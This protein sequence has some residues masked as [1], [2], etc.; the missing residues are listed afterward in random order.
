M[1]GVGGVAYGSAPLVLPFTCTFMF[2]EFLTFTL[3][4]GCA[5]SSIFTWSGSWSW[6]HTSNIVTYQ[7]LLNPEGTRST[8]I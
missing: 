7:Q 5:F 4:C 2:T 1:G 3:T 6:T 8:Q